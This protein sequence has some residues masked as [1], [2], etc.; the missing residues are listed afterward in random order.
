MVRLPKRSP[1]FDG[2]SRRE[3][4]A[5]A[6]AASERD[7][8]RGEVLVAEGT[9]PDSLYVL[10]SGKA[11][12]VR[13]D[14]RGT[15]FV[16]RD[17]EAGRLIG[18]VAALESQTASGTV[19][20]TEPARVLVLPARLVR[21]MPT[22][23]VNV[24][25]SMSESLQ[26]QSDL[27]LEHATERAAMGDLL[28]KSLVL[29]CAYAVLVSALPW[30]RETWPRAS[31]SY[32]SL[33]VIALFGFASVRFLRRTGWPLSRFGLGFRNLFGSLLEAALFTPL[34]AVVLV[35][36]KWA[37]IRA[38]P[39]WHGLP[40]I[41][42]TDVVTRLLDPDIRTLLVIYAA[43]AVVQELIVRCALQASLE[44]FLVSRGRT[45]LPIFVAAL[46]FAVNHLHMSFIFALLAFIPGLFWGWLF[47]R[48]RHLVG[49][50]LSHF[51]IGAFV[52]FVLGVRLQ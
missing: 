24:A 16:L 34:F 45:K 31:T 5:I 15:E 12:V 26:T 14:K 21:S 27:S 43:S 29:L 33:P 19:R 25:R 11:E 28:V 4:A 2:L 7:V 50:T 18:E 10:L 40:L 9:A 38:V 42:R 23:V 49:V 48:R 39:A 3:R 1:L 8:P 20:V 37:A 22:L 44:D 46:M 35:G 41:E 30:L 52:F 6:A 51:A 36:V 47:H 32:L 17:I 13:R